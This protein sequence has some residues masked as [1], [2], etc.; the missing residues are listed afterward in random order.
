[1]LAAVAHGVLTAGLGFALATVARSAAGGVV[2]GLVTVWALPM[3]LVPWPEILRL[4]PGVAAGHLVAG[5]APSTP[6]LTCSAWLA[7]AV[8][9]SWVALVARDA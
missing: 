9:A 5:S 7:A 2:L 1:M 4:L 3:L 8:V 6:A